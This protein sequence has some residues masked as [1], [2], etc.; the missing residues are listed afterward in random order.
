M[1]KGKSILVLGGI[2]MDFVVKAERVPK[3]GETL[4][5]SDFST[6]PGGKGANQ[7]VCI[8][9]LGGKAILGGR[10][11]K[12]SLGKKLRQ[13]L[14]KEEVITQYLTIDKEEHSGVTVII[15]NKDGD[16]SIVLDPG[17]N[18]KFSPQEAACLKSILPHVSIVLAQLEIPLET[19]DFIFDE[20]QKL[21]ITTVLDTGPARPLSASL[22]RNV[23]ILS[24]NQ[25][26]LETLLQREIKDSEQAKREAEELLSWGIK[27]VILKLGEKGS[28]LL[29]DE[30]KSYFPAFKVKAVDTTAAGD[31]FMGALC[32]SLSQGNSLPQAIEFANLAGA[33]AVTKMGA[34]PSLPTLEEIHK[35]KKPGR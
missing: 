15:I 31:A 26:E 1:S 4:I 33:Y 11:G 14:E 13:G 9:H 35:L 3:P 27:T 32:L 12:D 17:A 16:N 10:L 25:T 24:P 22:L 6:I 19:V 28:Y 2:N 20:A 34:Q 8:A 5:G 18:M 30:D 21:E 23:D 7:A 29:T